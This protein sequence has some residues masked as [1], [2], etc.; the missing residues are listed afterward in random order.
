MQ[1]LTSIMTSE[2]AL[3]KKKKA[4]NLEEKEKIYLFVFDKDMDKSWWNS[5]SKTQSYQRDSIIPYQKIHNF[6][7]FMDFSRCFKIMKK[8]TKERSSFYASRI[9]PR[10]ITDVI[11]KDVLLNL[12]LSHFYTSY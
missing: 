11:V 10:R 12:S 4:L 2:P 7:H 3:E 1:N 8:K 6:R 9:R 5:S